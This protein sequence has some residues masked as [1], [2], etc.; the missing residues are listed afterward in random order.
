MGQLPSPLSYAIASS[1]HISTVYII[2]LCREH[3]P[4]V[5]IISQS[6]GCDIQAST[7]DYY[8]LGLQ[9]ETGFY[10]SSAL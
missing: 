5:S 3:T 7:I 8:V 6:G 9:H 10:L 1:N 2:G 4:F